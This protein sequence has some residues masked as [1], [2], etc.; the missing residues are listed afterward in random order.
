[1]TTNEINTLF[2]KLLAKFGDHSKAAK[3][4]GI[5]ARHYRR[6]RAGDQPLSKPLHKLILKLID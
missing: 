4:L 3:E 1:M 6:I 5:T 2:E